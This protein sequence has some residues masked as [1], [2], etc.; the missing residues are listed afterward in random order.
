MAHFFNLLCAVLKH[1]SVQSKLCFSVRTF[2]GWGG[3]D[4][5]NLLIYKCAQENTCLHNNCLSSFSRDW[6]HATGPLAAR[7]ASIVC[8][9]DPQGL[10]L[11]G[12]TGRSRLEIFWLVER[13]M[14]IVKA[15][16][17]GRS[18]GQILR[19]PPPCGVPS[20][21]GGES[22]DRRNVDRRRRPPAPPPLNNLK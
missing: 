1:G 7:S 15:L 10:L 11:G 9:H 8:R 22:H 16:L 19:S 17:M 18:G 5:A 12:V 20:S 13:A 2:W 6:R 4:V 14:T 21:A 3:C